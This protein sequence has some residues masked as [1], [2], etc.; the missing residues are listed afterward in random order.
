M[1]TTEPATGAQDFD[2]VHGK[3]TIQ[4]RKLV[5]V[6]DP[7]CTEWVEFPATGE[8][9]PILDGIG[10][11]DR[12]YVTD[13]APGTPPFEGFTLRMFEPRSG[14]WR[15]WWSSTRAP[16]VLDPPVEGRFT[17]RHGVFECDD[18]LGGHQVRVRFE[19]LAENPE[20]PQ[21]QQSFSYDGGETWRL[22]WIMRFSRP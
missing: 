13:P 1:T 21:W 10:H 5:D 17:G 14:T 9:Y 16:G 11:I 22:N 15:I 18:T 7:A 12:M 2:F 8:A 6:T 20:T 3:W 4:N 19:W